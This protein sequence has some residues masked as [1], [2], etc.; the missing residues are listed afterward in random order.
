MHNATCKILYLLQGRAQYRD[1]VP[2]WN[3]NYLTVKV[4]QHRK[5]TNGY[6]YAVAKDCWHRLFV[7]R[8]FC[9]HESS[10]LMKDSWLTS[11]ETKVYSWENSLGH[12]CF[13]TPLT[14]CCLKKPKRAEIHRHFWKNLTCIFREKQTLFFSLHCTRGKYKSWGHRS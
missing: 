9:M 1:L 8:N 4:I 13:C 3:G 12:Y 2:F 5:V 6:I 10:L 7:S 14:W 11:L